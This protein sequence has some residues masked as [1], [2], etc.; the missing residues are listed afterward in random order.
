MSF[1]TDALLGCKH[2][3]AV[4]IRQPGGAVIL[5]ARE[6]ATLAAVANL[7]AWPVIYWAM[8]LWLG[9]FAY[10]TGWPGDSSPSAV[11]WC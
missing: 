11:C 8:D 4:E 5:L 1:L 9:T 10:R 3:I 6:F 7:L 2:A